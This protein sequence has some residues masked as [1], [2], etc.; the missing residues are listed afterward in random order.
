MVVTSSID[1]E[2]KT[3]LATNLALSLATIGVRTILVEGDLRN[4]ELT[5][6]LC[7][8]AQVGLV[9]VAMGRAPLHQAILVE[10]GQPVEYG[11]PLFLIE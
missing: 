8:R 7:P 6:S 5:R 4:P 11:Q 9:D 1:G 10:N 3:T 2:G